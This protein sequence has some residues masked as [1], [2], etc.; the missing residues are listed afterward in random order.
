[1]RIAICSSPL[2]DGHNVRGIGTYT[3]NLIKSL[4]GY[5]DL[6]IQEFSNIN[7]VKMADVVHYPY[8]DLFQKSLPFYTKFPTIVTIHDVIPLAYPKSYPA[9]IKGSFNKHL[10]V[11]SLKNVKAIITDS[12]ASKQEIIKYLKVP[13]KK[14]FPIALAPADNFHKITDSQRLTNIKE[15]YS[16]PEKFALFVG[17]VNWNKNIL[18]LTKAAL[19]AGID[20]VLIGKSF[21]EKGNLEHPEMKNFKEFLRLYSNNPKIHILG[22]MDNEDLVAVTNSAN[23]LLLPSIAEGFGLPILEAQVCGVPVITSNISS[24]PEVAQNGALLVDPYSIEDIS[25]AIIKIISEE[26]T[27]NE[28]IKLGYENVSK[29][30]WEKV[31]QETVDVYKI[32]I[33]GAVSKRI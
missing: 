19:D 11:L 27:R 10:Q 28:L 8:F 15:K 24:M 22:F 13:A 2:L 32:V 23:V 20:L 16:L 5:P 26:K 9:G 21:Q 29:F 12:K 18:N 1:M 3:K 17:S 7:E 6:N 31:A 33:Q 4:R 25:K 14:I 30:S